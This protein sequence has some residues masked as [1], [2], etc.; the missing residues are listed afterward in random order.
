[1]TRKGASPVAPAREDLG[2]I[3]ET[4]ARLAALLARADEES[5][6]LL[7]Q[8][9]ERVAA[10]EREDAERYQA[11]LAVAADEEAERTSAELAAIAR[12]LAAATARW[13][14]AAASE[15]PAL[16][17]VVLNRLVESNGKDGAR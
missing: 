5:R 11:A 6:V 12:E 4:E 10:M 16:V 8:V 14:Q 15:V 7:A 9:K 17:A 13:R 3:L 2:A 1:M